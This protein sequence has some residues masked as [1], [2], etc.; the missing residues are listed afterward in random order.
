MILEE[1]KLVTLKN[2]PRLA[3]KPDECFF[4]LQK[5][6]ENHKE[7]CVCYR[8]LVVIKVEFEYTYETY[9]N[10]TPEKLEFYLNEGTYCADNLLEDLQKV[11]NANG[12]IC[13]NFTGTYLREA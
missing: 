6:G 10:Q 8:K 3:G 2:G 5:I 7:N 13:P 1:T 4:C 11:S 12:C 9:V